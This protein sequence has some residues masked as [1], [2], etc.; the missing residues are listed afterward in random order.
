MVVLL[1]SLVY[2]NQ[3]VSDAE[4]LFILLLFFVLLRTTIT[5]C[6][7]EIVAVAGNR[8]RKNLD[9]RI[10]HFILREIASIIGEHEEEVL[11]KEELGLDRLATDREPVVPVVK[12]CIM[13]VILLLCFRPFFHVAKIIVHKLVPSR[14]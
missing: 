8:L 12:A 6:F 14:Y 9:L 13:L 10:M 11:D 2:L 1:K 3:V 7:S 5:H 4:L